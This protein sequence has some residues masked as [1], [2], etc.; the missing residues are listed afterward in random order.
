MRGSA[1]DPG[2]VALALACAVSYGVAPSMARLAYLAG[3]DVP[4][5][6]TVRFVAGVLTIGALIVIT[7]RPLRLPAR[8]N[9]GPLGLGLLSTL[10]SHRHM[11]SF[12]YI[13]PSLSLLIF[14]HFPP[15]F[16]V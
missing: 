1:A 6:T 12:L 9:W 4:T 16:A 10:T 3:T 7:R 13:P 5:A 14:F 11:W 8:E 2:G 15:L